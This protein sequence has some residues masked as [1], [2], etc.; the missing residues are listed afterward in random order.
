MSAIRLENVSKS[1]PGGVLAVNNVSV[2]IQNKQ[3]VMLA[4]PSGCGK[5]TLLRLIAGLEEPS[6]GNIYIDEQLANLIDPTERNIAV[7]YQNH[8]LYPHMSIAANM[9]FG[10]KFRK[11]NAK[12]IKERISNTADVLEI[13]HLMGK[14]PADLDVFE[15]QRVAFARALVKLP[16]VIL[17]DRINTAYDEHTKKTLYDEIGTIQQKLQ[18]TTI[19]A[20]DSDTIPVRMG[21]RTII[22]NK[23]SIEQIG[24]WDQLYNQPANTFV[25]GFMGRED[26][27][28]T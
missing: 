17:I 12:H 4:G 2:D 10:L 14:Y 5:S 7:V 3:L 1:F 24:T 28:Y 8:N 6:S 21:D 19:L 13:A 18:I 9:E 22:M 25:A 26:V 20:V 27:S 15:S 11:L 23:G 16:R